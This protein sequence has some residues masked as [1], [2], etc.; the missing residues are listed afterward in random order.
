MQRIEL[1]GVPT[2][3]SGRG[4]V[5][6]N[7]N[8]KVDVAHPALIGHLTGGAEFLNGTCSNTSSLNQA[9]GSFL[10][11]AEG[12][13]LDQAEGSFLDQAEGSFLD[14]AEGSFLDQSTASFLD[15][16]SPAHG[17]GTM[18]AGILA[19]VAPDAMIM[20]LRAFD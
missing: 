1:P 2:L 12:S 3:G 4:I 20:P 8:A 19:A 5:I 17:H 13:F 14:Q 6:A 7:V 18:V 16:M 9:E 10:D 15:Q 11:Q